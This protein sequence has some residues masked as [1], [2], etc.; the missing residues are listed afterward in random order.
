MSDLNLEIKSVAL[1]DIEVIADYISK[2]NIKAARNLV[3][4]FYETFNL[5]ASQPNLGRARKDFTYMDVKFY[6]IKKNY[7]IVYKSDDKTLT[8]LRVLTVHQDICAM[9]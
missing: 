3:S 2:D 5:L 1:S 9:F 6:V 4:D 7:L 8:I